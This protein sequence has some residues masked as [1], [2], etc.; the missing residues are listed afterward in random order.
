[1]SNKTTN[2]TPLWAFLGGAAIGAGA[3]MLLAPRSGRETR[4]MIRDG[5]QD[6]Y[7]KSRET[8]QSGYRKAAALPAAVSEAAKGGAEVARERF[9]ESMSHAGDVH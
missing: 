8:L 3:A 6:A 2:Y 4:Q 7:D 1:M 5:A 9:T